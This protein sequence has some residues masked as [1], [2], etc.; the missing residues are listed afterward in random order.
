ML[1]YEFYRLAGRAFETFYMPSVLNPAKG[2][3]ND[4]PDGLEKFSQVVEKKIRNL[5]KRKVCTM[6]LTVIATIFVSLTVSPFLVDF[7]RFIRLFV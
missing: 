3:P 1:Q 6:S 7:Q 5:E 2:M 4:S